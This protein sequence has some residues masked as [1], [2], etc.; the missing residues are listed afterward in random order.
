MLL[1][2]AARAAGNR[3]LLVATLV[4]CGTVANQAPDEMVNAEKESRK[5]ESLGGSPSYGGL[6]LSQEGWVSL[7]TNPASLSR[8]S[9][10]YYEAA[11]ATCDAALTAAGGRDSLTAND[12]RRVPSLFLEAQ[13]R[14]RLGVSL[15]DLGER[16][17]GLELLRQAVALLRL[18]VR[19]TAPG[20]D[21]LVAKQILASVLRNLAR[22]GAMRNAGS[23]ETAEAEACL[24]EALALCEDTD[25]VLL[26]QHILRDLANMSGRPDDPVRPAE[27]AGLRSRL[28]ALYAQAGRNHDASC[29]ICLETLEQSDGGAE[30]D[31]GGRGA[32]GYTNS[33]VFV[34]ECG[35]QFHRSCLSTWW[36]TAASQACPLCKM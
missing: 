5:Q 1:A 8:L 9:P 35:H 2:S 25:A 26:T 22:M 15:H 11:V 14:G 34:L 33:A 13:A 4:T 21:L 27:A 24:R 18:A 17:R 32:D 28:N 31:D 23:N 3:T 36:R 6:D 30:K 12:E 7:P 16:Q 20:S 19:K 29:T 10:A